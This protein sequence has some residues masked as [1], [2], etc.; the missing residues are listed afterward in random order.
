MRHN[1]R[2]D[3]LH[4]GQAYAELRANFAAAVDSQRTLQE[5]FAG[6][7]VLHSSTVIMTMLDRNCDNSFSAARLAHIEL[8]KAAES[9]NAARAREIGDSISPFIFFSS[10]ADCSC[11]LGLLNRGSCWRFGIH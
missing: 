1:L 11:D 10:N 8:L 2:V 7:P 9:E 3:C 5:L 6:E 4:V